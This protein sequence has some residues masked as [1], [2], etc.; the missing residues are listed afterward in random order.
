MTLPE[1]SHCI[2]IFPITMTS[3]ERWDNSNH[4]QLNCLF[5]SLFRSFVRPVGSPRKWPAMREVYVMTLS[6]N[7]TKLSKL[8][9]QI[10]RSMGPTWGPPGSCR[11]QMDPMLAPW[12]LL[13]RGHI[14]PTQVWHGCCW[15]RGTSD[16]DQQQQEEA[17]QH[18]GG[19]KEKTNDRTLHGTLS[20]SRGHF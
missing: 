20:I 8:P 14:G 18:G 4:R 1:I 3:C 13:S 7:T 10:A 16:E 5:N 9:T 12:T 19:W 6:E 11:P 15:R 17:T 2:Y